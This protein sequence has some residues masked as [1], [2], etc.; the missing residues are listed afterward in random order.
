MTPILTPDRP[1]FIL[2]R[3]QR[4]QLKK[5]NEMNTRKEDYYVI[6]RDGVRQVIC[7]WPGNDPLHGRGKWNLVAGPFNTAYEAETACPLDDYG[8]SEAAEASYY[9]DIEVAEYLAWLMP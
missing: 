4:E 7:V 2:S 9:G 8:D 6:E 5:E 3:E 1:Y